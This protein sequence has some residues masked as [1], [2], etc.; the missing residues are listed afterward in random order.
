MVTTQTSPAGSRTSTDGAPLLSV[1]DLTVEF[2]TAAGVARALDGVSFD[3][4]AGETLA[5]LGESG[6]GKSTTAQAIMALLPKPAGAI[7]GG[8]ILYG[9]RDL[10]AEPV[11]RVREVCGT[12]IA[13]I[14]QDPLSSLNPVFRVGAQVA[15]PFRRRRGM[16]KKEA[17]ARAL[18]L[19]RRVGIPDA[20]TR[21]N[22]YPHQF[23]GGQRQRIM[24]AMALALEPKLLVA[25]E[26]TTALD[27][28]V[29]KQVM[30]LLG[31]LQAE[32]G[33][34]MILISHDLGVVAEVAQRAAIMYAGRI[35]ETG[36]IRDMYDHPAHPY[37]RGLLESIPG[38]RVGGRLT[39]IV[40]SPPNLLNL[41]TGCAF[42]PRCPFAIDRCREQSPALRTPQG[43]PQG[44]AAACHRSEEVLAH[45]QL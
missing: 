22:D 20:E 27:V 9:G 38:G 3:V 39:P 10:A 26:P 12:E 5:I 25:D 11:R 37:T 21:I 34:A 24:I 30:N 44:H 29:Q 45:A 40:G 7:T 17:W 35:V 41:P 15:E 36:V 33:M 43:W 19:L 1:Q 32:T 23:S 4:A 28:T 2:S 42:S 14:F 16:A 31:D 13:M 8:R 6:C 18:E